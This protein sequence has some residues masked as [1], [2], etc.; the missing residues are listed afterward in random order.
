M[1]KEIDLSIVVT[2]H[3]EGLLAHKTMLSVF[4]GAKKVEEEGFSYEI[5]VHIDNGDKC[6]KDYFKRYNDDKR[7]KIFDNKFGDLGLSRNYAAKVSKGKYVSFLDGDDL[8]SDNWFVEALKILTKSKENLVVHPEAVLNFGINQPTV[9]TL[10]KPSLSEEEDTLLLLGENRWVSVAMAQREVFENTPYFKKTA[11]YNYEDYVF[12]IETVERG[13]RHEIAKGTVLFYRRS[14][15]SMLSKGNLEHATIPFVKLFDFE[16]IQNLKCLI[17]PENFEENKAIRRAN[18]YKRIRSNKVVNAFVTPVA[19]VAR[20]T[21]NKKPKIAKIVPDFV[22]DEWVKINHIETQLY[23]YQHLVNNTTVY[24]AGGQIGVGNAYC[25]IMAH[26][27]KKPKYVFIAPFVKRGGAEKVLVNYINALASLYPNDNFAIVTTL[28]SDNNWASKLPKQADIVDFGNFAKDLS[29]G[30]RETLFSRIIVQLQCQN[31]HLI[32]SEYGYR[33]LMVHKKLIS[34]YNLT[35]S[36]FA[37]EYIQGSNMRAT[38]SYDNPFL[39]SIYDEA[40]KIFTDNKNVIFE[41]VARNGYDE[42]KF[43]THYQPVINSKNFEAKKF[44]DGKIHIL[45]AGRIVNL[46]LPKIVAEIG[47]NLDSERFVIDIYGEMSDEVDKKMFNG[48]PVIK[49]HG[50]FDGFDN[51]MDKKYDIFLYTCLTDGIPNTVLEAAS[52][53]IPIIASNDG[54]VGEAVRDNETGILI[55]DLLDA[56]AYVEAIKK[57]SSDRKMQKKISSNAKKLV[58]ERHSWDSFIK[59]VKKDFA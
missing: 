43:T 15:D 41:T 23:P 39:F 13:I 18:R 4:E 33:W 6:T 47:K 11:G 37:S 14:D 8:V 32:N 29:Y 55:D 38:A 22:L 48:I 25:E 46:K 7:I 34:D 19:V 52:Y 50:S 54:G 16:N 56:N 58:D 2:V 12:N 21:I 40:K 35:V 1:K 53:G 44:D 9:L 10:Q 51:L 59:I 28:P 20:K 49:Y 17:R 3:D 24:S 45:W 36:L 57:L 5:I 42:K 26:V 31:I 27:R 30:E